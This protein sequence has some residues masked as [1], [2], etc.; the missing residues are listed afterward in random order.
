MNNQP[1]PTPKPT[2]RRV[3]KER[4]EWTIQY[5]PRPLEG[6]QRLVFADEPEPEETHDE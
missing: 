1:Q 4:S 5:A 6:Q 3:R 2:R